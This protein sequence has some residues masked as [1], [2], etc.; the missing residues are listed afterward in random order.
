MALFYNQLSTLREISI[1]RWTGH[2]PNT[3]VAE[4]HEF[5]D[6]STSAYGV[7]TYLKLTTL[8]GLV[9]ITLLSAKSKVA[10]LKT[11]SVPR[12]ELCATVLLARMIAFLQPLLNIS[13]LICYC[14]TDSIVAWL[15]QLP[16]RWK[17]FVANRVQDVQSQVPNAVWHH[18]SS[19]QNSADLA[20][21]GV[22]PS[23][24]LEQ[25]LWWKCSA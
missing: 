23:E 6:A 10:P 1:P 5:A 18:N 21:R 14:W 8:D 25:S 12:L 19:Q 2:G 13:L 15:K 9:Q 11:L 7:I 24:L 22:N 20:S 17:V 16:S 4:I 3:V